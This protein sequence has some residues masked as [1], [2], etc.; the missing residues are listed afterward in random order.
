MKKLND[1]AVYKDPRFYS[2]FPSI[3]RRPDGE[4]LVAFRRAPERRPYGAGSRHTD[5]NSYCVLVRS[6][7]DGATWTTEPDLIHAHAMGGSQDPCMV[8]LADGTILCASYWWLLMPANYEKPPEG[9]TVWPFTFGGGYIMRSADGGK[10]W[11]G[12]ILPPPIPDDT[13]R[14]PLGEMLPALNRGAMLEGSDGLLYWS[15][16]RSDMHGEERRTSVHLM[17]SDDK[18]DTWTYRCP[19]AESD[20]VTFN[21][22]SLYETAGGDIVAF[23]RTANFDDHTV[24]ARSKDRG[25]SFEAWEDAGFQGHPHHAVRLPDGRVFLVY[26]YR[27]EPYGIRCRALN[28]ECDNPAEAEELVLRDDGGSGDLG[29]PW[30]TVLPDGR[31]LAVYYINHINDDGEKGPRYIGGTFVDPEG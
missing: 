22:T 24:I 29:Y 5:P 3:V 4:L 12:P 8:Q 11:E 15:V 27:H 20:T 13:R 23:L 10:H 28:A 6:E 21:E 17:V 16:C 30:A 19:V 1:V 26:G 2:A 9:H 18:G 14:S 31:V 7:D 25:Q